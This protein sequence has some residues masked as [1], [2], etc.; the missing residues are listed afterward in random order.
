MGIVQKDAFR[1]MVISYVGIALGYLNKG[2]LFLLVLSTAQIGLVNLLVTVGS[3]FAQFANLGTVYSTWKFFPYFKNK[4]KKNHG[5]LPFILSIVAIG[6][7][8]CTLLFI[9]FQ[10]E[11]QQ[12]YEERSS[13]FSEY[14][15]LVLPIGISSVLYMTFEVYLRALY[16]NIVSV[17]A[18]EIG[19]RACLTVLLAM[20]YFDFIDFNVFVILQSFSYIL[21]V[22]ILIVYLSW[23]GEFNVSWEYM[24]ISKRFRRIIRNFSLF[25]YLNTLGIVFV[26]SMDVMM[27]AYFLG[28]EA[29]GVYTTVVFLA[30]ALQVPYKSV[31]RV[32]SPL[33]S[34]HWKRREIEKMKALYTKVSSVALVI[35]LI[36][37]LAIWLNIDFLFGFLKPEFQSGIWVFLFLMLGRL[38]DM[39]FGVNGSIF[40]TS[41]KYKYDI[42]FTCFLMASVFLLNCWFIPWWGIP[43]AAIST[44]FALIFYNVGRL[45]FVWIAYKIHPF[46]WNQLKVF[47]FALLTYLLGV[48]LHT[49]LSTS[50]WIMFIL[51]LAVVL[52]FLVIPRLW[53]RLDEEVASYIDKLKARMRPN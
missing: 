51:Q 43:G 27:I 44:S 35:G 21:P 50:G 2:F 24:T 46:S 28:L 8:L 5:F 52:F 19:L 23:L 10:H 34:D 33:V 13:A 40:V 31:I 18:L 17:F 4:E 6:I 45:I 37:F 53:F 7:A 36:P 9:V 12:L 14:Y 41:K 38:I 42:F 32:S 26:N 3:L 30:S 48:L 15:L 25:N 29:T 20:L 1:T 11:V 49:Y 16:K 47:S 22:L 39:Y